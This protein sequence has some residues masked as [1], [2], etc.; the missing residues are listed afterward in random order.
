MKYCTINGWT[1]RVLSKPVKRTP[2][3]VL[4]FVLE[5]EKVSAIKEARKEA[6]RKAKETKEEDY[7]GLLKE[8]GL[9][10]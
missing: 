5:K 1:F 9:P 4:Q 6:E 8:I 2:A 7:D 10:Y 3:E